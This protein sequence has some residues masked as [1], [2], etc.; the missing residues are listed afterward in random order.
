M[1]LADRRV[2]VVLDATLPAG[3]YGGAGT[4]GWKTN[5]ARN[6]WQYLDR[7]ATPI[8][9]VSDLKASDA[10]GGRAG[11]TV[12]FSAM[13]KKSTYVVGP[14]DEPIRAVVALGGRAESIAGACG[15]TAFVAGDCK[16]NGAGNAVACKR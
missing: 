12:K 4:R 9:G 8:G 10:G 6:L 2:V 5:G 11:G 3:L 16:F 13:G 7:T 14:G 15:E 1:V